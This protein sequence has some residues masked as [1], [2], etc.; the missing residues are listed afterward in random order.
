MS[1]TCLQAAQM[2]AAARAMDLTTAIGKSGGLD[3]ISLVAEAGT[4]A[5]IQVVKWLARERLNEEAFLQAMRAYQNFAHPNSNGQ[6]ILAQ[7]QALRP[8]SSFDENASRAQRK[9]SNQGIQ[10]TVQQYLQSLRG[11]A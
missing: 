11:S 5:G 9:R 6:V 2:A 4:T 1:G 7:L 10:N 3:L 8:S